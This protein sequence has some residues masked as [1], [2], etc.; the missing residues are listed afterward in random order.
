MDARKERRLA[1]A[2]RERIRRLEEQGIDP[3]VDKTRTR[4]KKILPV[5]EVDVDNHRVRVIVWR[6]LLNE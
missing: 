4:K 2:E 6:K 5:N 1:R 3:R